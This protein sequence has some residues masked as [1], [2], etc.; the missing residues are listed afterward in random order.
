MINIFGDIAG[1]EVYFD[2]LFIAAK[3]EEEH[4]E[5][6][7]RVFERARHNNIKFNAKK[8][9]YRQSEVHFMGQVIGN[10]SIKPDDKHLR[11][12]REMPVP[13]NKSDVLRFLGLCKYVAK[14]IPNLAIIT[15]HLRNITRNDVSWM[16]TENHQ[17][18]YDNLR[19]MLTTAPVLKLFDPDEPLVI[20]ADASKMELVVC[21]YNMGDQ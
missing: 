6:L 5:I 15:T 1:V 9:Q 13:Q 19:Q 11:A 16:W 21:S 10:G 20:Q 18:E 17:R 4:D 3:S 7:A 2:D 12:I 8:V 14:Y